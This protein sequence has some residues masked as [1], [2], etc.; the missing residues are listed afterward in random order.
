MSRPKIKFPK[1]PDIKFPEIPDIEFPDFRWT[2]SDFV[3]SPG[4]TKGFV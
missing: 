2:F 3:G 4:G 1:M